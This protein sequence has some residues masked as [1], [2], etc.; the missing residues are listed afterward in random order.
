MYHGGQD[1]H[2]TE[3]VTLLWDVRLLELV[4]ALAGTTE[5]RVDIQHGI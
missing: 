2:Q 5:A 3:N 1:R 4:L